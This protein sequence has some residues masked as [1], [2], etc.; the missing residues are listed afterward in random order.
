MSKEALFNILNNQYYLEDLSI[1]DLFSGTG[2]ISYEFASRGAQ[3]ITAVDGNIG[4]VR[5]ITKTAKELNYEISVIKSDVFQFLKKHIGQYDIVFADPPYDF[6]L[7]KF[8]SI[9]DLVF[10]Q[11]LL[12]DKGVLIVEHSEQTDLSGHQRFTRSRKYGG[13]L[14]SFFE[15]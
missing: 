11:H 4:C 5:F 13:N 15:N 12:S 7:E 9:V 14:F 3:N 1:L 6:D 8:T 10:G 2:N